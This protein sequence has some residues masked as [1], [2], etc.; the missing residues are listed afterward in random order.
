MKKATS[1]ESSPAGPAELPSSLN[2]VDDRDP[3][4]RRKAAAKGFA[5]TGVDG[6]PVKDEATLKRIRSLVI[7]PAWRDVWICPDPS[8]H[9][10][11]TGRDARGRKQYR[12]HADWRKSRDHSK[13]DKMI[14]FG[15]RLPKL[16]ARIEAD[17]ALRG[18]PREKVVAAVVR[19]LELTLIRVGNDAYARENK[20]FGLT[21]MRKRH[22]E[23]G[24]TGAVFEFR[25]KSGVAHKTG[26]RDRKLARVVRACGD[27][28]GQRLFQ[29]L[30]E[31]GERHSV[32]SSEVN[33]YIHEAIGDGFS[34]K[35]F[36]TWAGALCALEIFDSMEPPTSAIQAKAMIKACV[37]G[38]SRRLG[39]T[40]AVCRACYIHPA[41]IAAF[42]A[43]EL[44][45]PRAG[46]DPERRLI[47]LLEGGREEAA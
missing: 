21:T 18:L 24:A 3:G 22:V 40:P 43:G 19:L 23:L 4:I 33:A 14:D 28:P 9:I 8:G 1:D 15:R 41:V 17:L 7:P 2:Y 46:A 26:F 5:Y 37:D 42:E 47:R 13:Y 44:T 29:Y 12:Y 34:A 38:V 27:L 11:A 39:N 10:Q 20:S 6:K 31:D 35:D 30:D 16:R 45:R 25:G 32:G 36:R